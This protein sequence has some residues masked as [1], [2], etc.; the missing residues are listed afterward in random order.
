MWNKN[1]RNQTTLTP[2]MSVSM[3]SDKN[4]SN[5][6]ALV[7]KLGASLGLKIDSIISSI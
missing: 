5:Q 3:L 4:D 7:P 2:S 1:D 6:N